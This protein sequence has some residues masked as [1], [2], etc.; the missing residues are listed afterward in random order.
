M[1]D[2]NRRQFMLRGGGVLAALGLA[3]LGDSRL[4]AQALGATA[5]LTPE[6]EATYRALVD[7]VVREVRDRPVD[8]DAALAYFEKWFAAQS[9][10]DRGAAVLVLDRI[11]RGPSSKA[12]SK[13]RPD[14]NHEFLLSWQALRTPSE[15]AY[16]ARC[17]E[18]M[19]RGPGGRGK[20]A[21][22][23][24]DQYL[25]AQRAE[26]LKLQAKLEKTWGPHVMEVDQ[27]T[28][29]SRYQPPSDGVEPEAQPDESDREEF[30]KR[31]TATAAEALA[32]VPFTPEPATP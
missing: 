16:E 10:D 30:K 4:L 23:R 8:T 14:E 1:T 2:L 18:N 32:R 7:A 11:E 27:V 29:V 28:L 17:L 25:A 6:R 26:G 15:R 22:R 12:L 13:G 20:A 19:E 3:T 9:E 24:F 21:E 31:A 5:E